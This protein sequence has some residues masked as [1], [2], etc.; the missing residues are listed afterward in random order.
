[1]R[2]RISLRVVGT[3]RRRIV[4]AVNFLRRQ[5]GRLRL[6]AVPGRLPAVSPLLDDGANAREA[7]FV[8]GL[9][10]IDRAADRGVHGGA[11]QFFGGN[12]LPDGGLH[13]RRPGQE[14]S[15]A[16][17]HQHVI[18]HHRQVAA[19]GHAHAHDGGDLRNPHGRHHRV[20]AEDAAEI[21]GVGKNIFLQRQEDAGRIHQV[22][23]RH[24]VFDRDV[25]GANHFL[26]GHRERT[27]PP[28]PWRRW[29]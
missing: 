2:A 28:S 21:V 23:R 27:R 8:V 15:A 16:V 10:K 22:N 7:S 25:L 5:R 18:A 4:D 24:P 9:A 19:A 13:Q 6:P 14:K 29:R 3:R 12:L 20:V 11:A 26:R 17:G 1:M